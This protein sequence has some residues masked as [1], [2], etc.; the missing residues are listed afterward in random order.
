MY[1]LL[2]TTFILNKHLEIFRLNVTDTKIY[3]KITFIYLGN[4]A[5]VHRIER[6]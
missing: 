1:I 6:K 2:F 3:T 4:I 5:H